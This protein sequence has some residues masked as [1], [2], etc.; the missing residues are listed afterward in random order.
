MLNDGFS[1]TPGGDAATD[2]GGIPGYLESAT[3]GRILE[4]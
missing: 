1:G 2:S 4:A 3:S